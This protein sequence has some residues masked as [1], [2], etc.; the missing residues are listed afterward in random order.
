MTSLHGAAIPT[1]QNVPVAT[2]GVRPDL[3]QARDTSLGEAHSDDRV[4]EI[5]ANWNPERFDPIAVVANPD[6]PGEYIVISGHH[7]LEAVKRLDLPAVPVRV[8]SGD[9]RDAGERQRL[10]REAGRLA[11]FAGDAT[12]GAFDAER[13]RAEDLETK[14]RGTRQR[15]TSCRSLADELGVSI[16]DVNKV[17]GSRLSEL[18]EAQEKAVRDT[19][20]LHRE[21]ATGEPTNPADLSSQ[22]PDGALGDAEDGPGSEEQ[23]SSAPSHLEAHPDSKE[24]LSEPSHYVTTTSE[25]PDA[26]KTGA[27]EAT[28]TPEGTVSTRGGLTARA[29]QG[30]QRARTRSADALD[31]LAGG[32]REFEGGLQQSQAEKRKATKTAAKNQA[33]ERTLPARAAD[34]FSSIAARLGGGNQEQ[35]KDQS[36]ASK[37]H[38]PAAKTTP[39]LSARRL[40]QTLGQLIPDS[41]STRGGAGKRKRKGG[42]SKRSKDQ[43]HENKKERNI[44]VTFRYEEPK[45]AKPKATRRRLHDELFG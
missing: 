38:Q 44:V 27:D 16:E 24:S 21:Q 30:V 3:F 36:Q 34:L 22:P 20:A 37:A 31:K 33:D 45:Q 25:Q 6:R 29:G 41:T 42:A 8:L 28:T 10:E 5:V 4:K 43:K 7:R 18:T 19:I 13:K 17:A 11:G 1:V 2:V 9:I 12:L 39:S 32:I 35:T 40:G 15:L 14:I 23:S 26:A